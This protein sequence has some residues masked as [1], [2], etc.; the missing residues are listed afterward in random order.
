MRVVL[1]APGE[2]QPAPPPEFAKLWQRHELEDKTF[3][4]HIYRHPIVGR[5]ELGFETFRLP[6]DPD[7]TMVA[8]HVEPGSPSAAL[9]LLAAV[10]AGNAEH[11]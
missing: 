6:D 7:Q 8:H 5:L 1:A 4:G 2:P 3:G 11:R 9:R 10:A